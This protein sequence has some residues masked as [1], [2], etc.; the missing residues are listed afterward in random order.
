MDV[1]RATKRHSSDTASTLERTLGLLTANSLIFY[2][3]AVAAQRIWLVLNS[4]LTE[5]FHRPF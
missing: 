4:D 2:L 5:L 3:L 1:F